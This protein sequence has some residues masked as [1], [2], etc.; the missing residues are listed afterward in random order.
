M[1]VKNKIEI[2]VFKHLGLI[3]SLTRNAKNIEKSI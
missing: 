2:T 1:L 3:N